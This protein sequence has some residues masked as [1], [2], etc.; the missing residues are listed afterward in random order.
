[1]E[2]F[3][4]M[5]MEEKVSATKASATDPSPMIMLL[6]TAVAGITFSSRCAVGRHSCD[7]P[8]QRNEV[9]FDANQIAKAFSRVAP[10]VAA[11]IQLHRSSVFR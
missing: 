11:T 5:K 3:A 9:G 2:A 10:L 6:R 1:V 7:S 4:A 8:G